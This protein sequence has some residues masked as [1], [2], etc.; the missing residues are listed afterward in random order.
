MPGRAAFWWS[1]NTRSNGRGALMAY[2]P[3]EYWYAAYRR[4]DR[5]VLGQ[6]KHTSAA[7]LAAY[8]HSSRAAIAANSLPAGRSV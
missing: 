6:T 1:G 8:A 4:T 3:S 7:E 5:W 2:L